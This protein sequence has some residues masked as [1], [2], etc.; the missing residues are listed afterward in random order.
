M[1]KEWYTLFLELRK[2][3]KTWGGIE[4][5]DTLSKKLSDPFNTPTGKALASTHKYFLDGNYASSY[6][7]ALLI[8]QKGEVSRHKKIAE[9]LEKK[10]LEKASA[11]V[12]EL[13][14]IKAGGA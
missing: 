11:K 13:D 7:T 14:E 8:K 4:K 1:D 10:I 9:V 5:I 3:P 2:I 6:K 12:S